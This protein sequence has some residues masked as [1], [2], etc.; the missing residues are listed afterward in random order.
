MSSAVKSSKS[1]AAL[2][3]ARNGRA[4]T[5]DEFWPP[6]PKPEAAIWKPFAVDATLGKSTRPISKVSESSSP[7][8]APSICDDRDA[9]VGDR[10]WLDDGDGIQD[11]GEPGVASVTVNLYDAGDVL[12]A[13]TITDASGAYAFSPGPGEYY[14]EFVSPPELAFAPRDR[15]HDDA[16]DSDADLGF[17]TTSV[18]SLNA[19]E[20]DLSRD[21]GFEPV[22]IGNRVWD[23]TNGD[24]RQQPG[25]PGQP[26]IAVRLLDASGTE[27]ATSTT[28]A[29]GYYRFVGVATGTYRIEVVATADGVFSSP[30]VGGDTFE[31][32]LI[33]S[34]V[35][36]ATGRS[37]LFEYTAGSANRRWDAGLRIIPIFADG[38]ESGDFSAWSA[39]VD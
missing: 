31:G 7:S 8:G 18:F 5:V 9:S 32:D 15:G 12:V 14:L 21:A 23:D 3:S 4:T 39:V 20:A 30:D 29:A 10:V 25:E 19:G 11:G 24:G 28:D 22:G 2:P 6:T 35:D 37:E 13:S 1:A 38:F 26:G 17:G 34:D 33:D 36:P 27:V 16:T